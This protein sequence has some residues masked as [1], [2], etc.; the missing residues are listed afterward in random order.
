M[1]VYQRVILIICQYLPWELSKFPERRCSKENLAA[2]YWL[3]GFITSLT[4]VNSIVAHQ[5]S[6]TISESSPQLLYNFVNS[7]V[8]HQ[9]PT[10]ISE[11]SPQLLYNFVNL[12]N[13]SSIL[14]NHQPS[15]LNHRNQQPSTIFNGS[16]SSGAAGSLSASNLLPEATWFGSTLTGNDYFF[17][18]R[19]HCH[20]ES[21]RTNILKII[22][23]ILLLKHFYFFV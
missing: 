3:A 6:T 20:L 8:A 22:Y 12:K 1:L 14:I 23:M 4:V 9:P 16:Q 11:S 21:S 18:L 10:T 19:K 17:W 15:F 13:S 7:I 2:L 5:P